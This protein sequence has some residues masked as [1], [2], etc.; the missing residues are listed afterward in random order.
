M[1][2]L[3]HPDGRLR[4]LRAV[5]LGEEPPADSVPFRCNASD[6]E[7]RRSFPNPSRPTCAV[8]WRSGPSAS[9]MGTCSRGGAVPRG[10]QQDQVCRAALARQTAA[11]CWHAAGRPAVVL[12]VVGGAAKRQ[13]GY[14]ADTR[15]LAHALPDLT[16][17]SDEA[18]R[19][20]RE[21]HGALFCGGAVCASLSL[22]R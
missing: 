5:S 19:S 11:P 13:S 7:A 21:G 15:F 17:L 22:R 18:L 10:R 9:L 8:G 3:H 4:D 20:D 6:Q 1:Q 14:R 16:S 12:H 2:T